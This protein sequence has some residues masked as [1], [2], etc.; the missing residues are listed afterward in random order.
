MVSVTKEIVHYLLSPNDGVVDSVEYRR[1]IFVKLVLWASTVLLFSFSALHFLST[2]LPNRLVSGVDFVAALFTLYALIDLKRNQNVN[3]ASLIATSSLFVFFISFALINQ[4]ESFGLIWLIFFPIIAITINHKKTGFIFSAL[5]LILVYSLAFLGIGEWQ[6]GLW[7]LE[8]FLRLSIALTLIVIVM[9]VHEAAMYKA[10]AFELNTLKFFETL[11]LVDD[12][13]QLANRRRID[14]IL[15]T[16]LKRS[17]RYGSPF[18]VV[19]FDIDHFKRVNDTYGHL[20]GD[21][22]LKKV[23]EVA[24]ENTRETET[25]GRWGGEEF[26]IILPEMTAQQA[27]QVAEKLRLAIAETQFSDIETP[28]TCSFGVSQ[29]DKQISIEQLVDEVDCALYEAKESG[30][31]AVAVCK[32]SAN[33]L[34]S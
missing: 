12:L 18:S 10:Q 8:S 33:R 29:Y 16:E 14:E 11:S 27:A 9:Y 2:E 22:V 32:E 13:T 15:N 3:R 4:N 25:V 6:N 34:A 21:H 1:L 23:A 31:N 26:L 5:F 28:I 20:V 19:L 17:N 30:R 24:S 7:N